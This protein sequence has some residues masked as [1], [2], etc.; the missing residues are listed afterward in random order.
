[1]KEVL[2]RFQP[3]VPANILCIDQFSNLGGGQQSL[4]SML[5]AFS[6]RGWR[7]SVAIPADGPFPAMIRGLGYRTHNFPCS[8]YSSKRKPFAEI[9]QYALELP[10]LVDRFSELVKANETD[11]I[12]VNGPRLVPP[13]AWVAWRRGIPLVFHCHNRL[14]QNSAITLTGQ[15][16][17]LA[18]A[19]VIACCNYAA[20]PLREYVA[21]DRLSILYNG[22]ADITSERL[23]S[24]N[25]IR[26]IGVVGRI[27]EGKGQLE[28]VQAARLILQQA[29]ECR[30]SVIGA[31][32]FSGIGYYS[33]VVT[34]SRGLP[35]DFVDWQDDITQIYSELSLLVVPSSASEATTR[36][37][38]EAY[39]AG[40]P[41]VAFPVGGIPEILEDEETGFLAKAA[42]VEALAQ[43]ILSVLR[44]NRS[45][46]EA[47]VRKARK[48][49]NKR[50]TLQAYRDGVCHV[51]T[52]A[53]RPVAL[54]S[55]RELR[56]SA[57]VL[58]D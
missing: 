3:D 45:S 21:P 8:S 38:L 5:P 51:L 16:L 40:V 55:Y 50:F 15:A 22:V 9:L 53:M 48:D 34:E 32:M 49:W 10:T 33:K 28:F 41:V 37:I 19:H 57:G 4:L 25:K 20:D 35:I 44:R 1:M 17:E 13:A 2:S 43:R 30:F 6:E 24:P 23:R 54:R 58:T 11:L 26:R 56:D 29:P 39:S 12:Y 31:P 18:S 46:V 42:T 27:E 7:T 52:Q 14:L 36:V 47:V